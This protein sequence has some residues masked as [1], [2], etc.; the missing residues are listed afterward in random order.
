MA[1][2]RRKWFRVLLAG[3]VILSLAGIL[4]LLWLPHLS[5]QGASSF[6]LGVFALAG[7]ACVAAGA[8]G[9]LL[10]GERS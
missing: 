10:G 9:I 2:S 5:I 7:L 3:L 6:L 4:F 1:Q 8:L